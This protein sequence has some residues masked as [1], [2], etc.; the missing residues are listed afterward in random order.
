M[1]LV[2]D[3]V[4]FVLGVGS[5]VLSL[6]ND[7]PA[8]LAAVGPVIALADPV[9]QFIGNMIDR[10]DKSNTKADVEGS[11]ASGSTSPLAELWLL[12][13]AL[14]KESTTFKEGLQSF[15][16]GNFEKALALFEQALEARRGEDRFLRLLGSEN[17]PSA[18][19]RN[20][21]GCCYLRLAV[22]MSEPELKVEFFQ[23]A[24]ENLIQAYNAYWSIKGTKD[25][26][27]QICDNLVL[28]HYERNQPGDKEKAAYY[29]E[30]A[31][32]IASGRANKQYAEIIHTSG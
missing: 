8:W 12:R 11:T 22:E 19:I 7:W 27:R 6:K 23:Q 29:S 18:C 21:I 30:K 20:N 1:R 15:R 28:F 24:Y 10:R 3:I 32:E 31:V 13:Y 9:F 2:I 14:D 5:V 16:N 26:C 17:L 25:S 4:A